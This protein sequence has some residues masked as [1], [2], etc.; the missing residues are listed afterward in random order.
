SGANQTECLT[1]ANVIAATITGNSDS[2]D[3]KDTILADTSGVGISNCGQIRVTKATLPSGKTGTFPYAVARADNSA[4]KFSGETTLPGTLTSDGDSDLLGDI[5]A[6]T[7]YT[8]S[9][10]QLAPE[11]VL[12]SI[13]CTKGS[14]TYDVSPG[15]QHFAVTPGSTTDCV[16]TNE[17]KP[18][19]TLV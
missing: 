9:E 19:L 17:Q 10:G 13:T 3:F 18:K 12:K 4:L 1:F 16:I 2:A 14:T 11:W 6:G 15:G 7:N 5:K 8:L